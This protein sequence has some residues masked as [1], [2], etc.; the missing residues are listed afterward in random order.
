MSVA[1]LFF[2]T[3]KRRKLVFERVPVGHDL[4]WRCYDAD[5]YDGVENTTC[6]YGLTEDQAYVDYLEN[7]DA[8]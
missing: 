2:H 1:E 7:E 8:P 4:G 3:K 5:K 6:G